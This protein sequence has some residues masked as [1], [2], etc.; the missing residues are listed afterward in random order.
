MPEHFWSQSDMDSDLSYLLVVIRP[1]ANYFSTYDASSVAV[2]HGFNCLTACGILVSRPGVE[3]KSPAL[4]G[5][6]L[7]SGPPGKSL[8]V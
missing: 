5:G 2:A 7:T 3:P 1:R 8:L 6:F 4:E